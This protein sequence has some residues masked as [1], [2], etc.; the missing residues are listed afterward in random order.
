M[1]ELSEKQQTDVTYGNEYPKHECEA[2]CVKTLY[3]SSEI[4]KRCFELGSQISKD[5]KDKQLIAVGILKGSFMFM[6]D[7]TRYI[8][9]PHRV[10]FMMISSY[11]GTSQSSNV[12]ISRDMSIDPYNCHIL[13]I[14]D[15]IDSGET[16]AS[17][18]LHLKTK[19]VHLFV[20]VVY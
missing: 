10:D 11:S 7:L 17:L 8:T 9:I 19:N 5:Y 6:A 20:Y 15:L 16:L 4:Q 14:E 2:N 3:T 12:K 18:M 1:S 13:I